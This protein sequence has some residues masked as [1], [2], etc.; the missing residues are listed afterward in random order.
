[1][2]ILDKFT[3]I[4][5]IQ[6]RSASIANITGNVLQFNTATAPELH[7]APYIQILINP[8]DKQFAI[9]A[10]KEDAPN[11][12]PFSKPEGEQKLRIR[13][14]SIPIV[15]IIRKMANWSP[16]ES[17]NVP[18]VYFAED[19]ALVYDIAAAYKPRSNGGGWTRKRQKEEEATADFEESPIE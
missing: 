15:D 2:S 9:R 5:L 1:M 12:I 8:K 13:T 4:D 14:R 18:G 6:T 7:Y 11:A 16:Q 17:W 3:V 10:C 19:N